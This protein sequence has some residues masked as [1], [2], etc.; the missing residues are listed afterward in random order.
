MLL[1]LQ[2]VE[3]LYPHGRRPFFD[4]HFIKLDD[5]Y[6]GMGV[7]EILER[8]QIEG[9][10]FYQCRSDVLEIIT[11]PGGLVD[12]MSGLAP[13]EI[14]YRPGMFIKARDPSSAIR[15]FHFPVDPGLLFREQSGIEMQTERVVGS[16]DMGLGR[17]P[18]RPNAPRT[19]GGTSIM[20]Q[21]Q[22]LRASV[23]LTRLMYGCSEEPSGVAE[24]LMQYKDLYVALMPDE[25]EFRVIG[26][27]ELRKISRAD[28]QGRYDFIIDFGDQL[29]NEQIRQQN[30]MFRYDRLRDNQMVLRNPHAFWKVTTD[31]MEATGMRNA[32]RV[33]PAP[34]GATHP[35]MEQEQENQ[36]LSKGI[37]VEALPNDNHAGHLAVI[38]QLMQDDMK[39]AEQFSPAEVELLGRHAEEHLS[40][41]QASMG[42]QGSGQNLAPTRGPQVRA[43]QAGMETGEPPMTGSGEQEG[44]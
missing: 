41:M 25:K 19:L 21:Q 36:I 14:R 4:W 28:L 15:E 12:P 23:Y 38:Q 18:T 44:F 11:K 29:N 1:G 6:A 22:K 27:D 9:N 16:T 34:E 2:R 31:F 8:S 5:R 26:T 30:S 10:A 32:A 43:A 3:Y 42:T 40:Y 37:Y 24:F 17:G 35:P 13:E 7:P 20:V 33:L 39:F